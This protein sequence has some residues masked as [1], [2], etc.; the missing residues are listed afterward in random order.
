[1]DQAKCYFDDR[2]YHANAL[3]KRSLKRRNFKKWSGR[4]KTVGFYLRT[5]KI[6]LGW[7]M[8]TEAFQN[9]YLF[10]MN[11]P[12]NDSHLWH[13]EEYKKKKAKEKLSL[14]VDSI[15]WSLCLVPIA[16]RMWIFILMTDVKCAKSWN[17]R[18]KY[19]KSR[20]CTDCELY[21]FFNYLFHFPIYIEWCRNQFAEEKLHYF[22]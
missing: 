5:C 2:L 20:Y 13:D 14:S 10:C 16:I 3:K 4:Y 17:F 6:A 1:M 9:F 21:F 18:W 7:L 8:Q 15:G 11:L 22:A 19:T 12:Q